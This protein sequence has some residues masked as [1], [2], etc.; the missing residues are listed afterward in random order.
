MNRQALYELAERELNV[1]RPDSDVLA[2]AHSSSGGVSSVTRQLYWQ[3]RSQKLALLAESSGDATKFWARYIAE[4][5]EAER[6][7]RK[8]RSIN[9]WAGAFACFSGWVI[10]YGLFRVAY[11]DLAIGKSGSLGYWLGSAICLIS[12]F[13]GFLVAKRNSF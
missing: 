13:Y 1:H 12:G 2:T 3:F 9:A 10:A 4:L 6:K 11:H 5:E 7:A 8:Q